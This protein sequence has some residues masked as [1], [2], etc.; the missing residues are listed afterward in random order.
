MQSWRCLPLRWETTLEQWWCASPIEWAAANGHYEVVRELLLLDSNHLIKLT[1]LRRL[2]RL[3]TLWEEDDDG[4]QSRDIATCRARVVRELLRECESRRGANGSHLVRAGYGGWIIYTAASA[5]ELGFVEELIEKDPTIVFGEGEYGVTDVLYAAAKSK[6]WNVFRLVFESAASPGFSTCRDGD[7][8]ELKGGVPSKY[9]WEMMNRALHAAARGGSLRALKELAEHCPDIPAYRDIAGSTVL[10]SA[11]AKGQIEV[12]KYLLGAFDLAGIV[13]RHGNTALHIAAYRG[14]LQAFRVLFSASPALISATNHAG[15]TFLH[16]AIAG[17]QSPDFQRLD[18]Q[19]ALLTHIAGLDK[20]L[21][22]LIN[23]RSNTG[24]TALHLAL[25]GKPN[26]GAVRLLMSV[27][28]TDLN[29]RDEYGMTPLDIL[30][31]QSPSARKDVLIRQ[32]VSAGAEYDDDHS[33]SSSSPA[34]KS[35]ASQL[36]TMQGYG[37]NS[38]GTLFSI[39]DFEILL[40]A[41]PRNGSLESSSSVGPS[42][43]TEMM[44]FSSTVSGSCSSYVRSGSSPA[45]RLKKA[46][47]PP[48]ARERKPEKC[49]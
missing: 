4:R 35:M 14:Q 25:I 8:E 22:E 30:K 15:E 10:H 7:L 21:Q 3:E 37:A 18:R 34:I 24:R 26:S 32:L 29:V 47:C 11:A 40:H 49:P 44:S 45:R 1:S 46:L 20:P 19:M 5:G 12:I 27:P 16:M 42:E 23:S 28:S 38:P 9:R 17:F 6:D 36:K 41:V 43:T 31:H 2:R 33:S 39:P 48:S 13:D